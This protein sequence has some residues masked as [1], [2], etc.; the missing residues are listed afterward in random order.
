MIVILQIIDKNRHISKVNLANFHQP[1]GRGSQMEGS[2]AWSGTEGRAEE[3]RLTS[4]LADPTYATGVW[5]TGSALPPP[6]L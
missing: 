3:S 6:V 1:K 4:A 5:V 2:C